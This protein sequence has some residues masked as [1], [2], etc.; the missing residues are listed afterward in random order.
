MTLPLTV[1]LAATVLQY[2]SFT[3]WCL[4]AGVVV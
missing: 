2:I 1:I 3:A 4:F